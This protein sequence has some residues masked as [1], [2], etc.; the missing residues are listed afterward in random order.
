[1]GQAQQLS[2]GALHHTVTF[3]QEGEVTVSF[4]VKVLLVF[5]CLL[6][7]GGSTIDTGALSNH[8]LPRRLVRLPHPLPAGLHFTSELIISLKVRPHLWE[9]VTCT[10]VW[11]HF[12]SLL[13]ADIITDNH[14]HA[15]VSSIPESALRLLIRSHDKP[16]PLLAPPVTRTVESHT[17]A[18]TIEPGSFH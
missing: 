16:L 5:L 7:S 12:H 18:H 4:P 10:S 14:L 3:N 15:E 13:G 17:Q 6:T 9:E 8:L 11:Y 1:M 2:S